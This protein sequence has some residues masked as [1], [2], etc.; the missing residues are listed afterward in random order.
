MKTS[1]HLGRLPVIAAFSGNFIVAL[2]KFV[3]FLVT[4]SGS[5]FSEAIHSFADTANQFLLFVGLKR[6][7]KKA[8]E[9]HPYGHGRERYI[10][11]L[12]SACGIFFLGC[13]VTVYHGIDVL[14]SGH[15]FTYSNWAI[16]ILLAS[17]IIESFTLWLAVKEI[18]RHFPRA[19]WKTINRDADPTTLAVV[20]EDGLAVIGVLIAFV[21]I[22]LAK[23]TGNYYWDAIGSIAIGILLG[24]VAIILINKN[25]HFLIT[26]SIPHKMAEEVKEILLADP[27]IEKIYD[28]KSAVF[29]ADKYLVKCE[30]EFNASAMM[31]D[32]DRHHF[33]ANEYQEVQGDPEEFKKFCVEYLDRV[34]R[35]VGKKI[36]EIEKKIKERFPEIVFIDIEIN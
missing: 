14:I 32:L 17:F 3:G 4:G 36:D 24:V 21:G 22:I 6:S 20:M 11:A 9:D 28:F 27:V 1:H 13:G 34:P 33:I 25:R 7:Q 15:S 35:L 16:F 8:S 19:K 26:K 10:W 30:V 23:Y 29:D 2:A 18:R 12:I 31:K 5:M